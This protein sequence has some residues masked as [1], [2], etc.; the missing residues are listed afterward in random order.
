M[1]AI[2]VAAPTSGAGKT[3]IAVGL[4][5]ALARRGLRVQGFKVGPDY[6]DPTYHAIATGRPSRNLDGWLLDADAL[7]ESFHR[8]MVGADVAVIEGVMGLFDGRTGEGERASTAEVAKRLGAPVVLVL[9]AGKAA[10]SLA[11]I[12]FGC[13][14]FDPALPFAGVVLNRIASDAHLAA[15]RGPIEQEA[16]LTLLG[17]LR[18]DPDLALPERYLG[19][20]PLPENPALGAV[21]ERAADA[22]S[23]PTAA[24]GG[25][26]LDRLLALAECDPPRPTWLMDNCRSAEEPGRPIG[27][28]DLAQPDRSA[29]AGSDG[30]GPGWVVA[31][32]SAYPDSPQ[33]RRA[34]IALARDAAF[35]FYYQDNLDLLAAWGAELV[36]FSPL[37]DA[38]LPPGT[39]GIYLGGG[40][41][42]LHAAT[43]A[44]NDGLRRAIL[45]ADARGVPIWAECGGLMYL[46][47]GLTDAEGR[48]HRM[49]GLLPGWTRFDRRRLTLGYRTV[50]ARQATPFTRPGDRLRGHEFHWSTLEG[51]PES[52]PEIAPW[53]IVGPGARPD[54]PEGVRPEG[55]GAPNRLASYV[56]LHLAGHPA[57][58][59][60]FVDACAYAAGSEAAR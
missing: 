36:P 7:L 20:V 10:R 16:G 38:D 33:P 9:D 25:I 47:Q 21:V 29:P 11:A 13:R 24:G 53:E 31:A 44:A 8:A 55:Y 60:R 22:V 17:H 2:V 35:H 32:R 3:T 51:Y 19:L 18:R 5:R 42:E 23:G 14:H 46:L 12:A 43:L 45:A 50:R 26:D 39:S 57:L 27:R 54:A 40:F 6:I 41:P 34:R 1:K 49:V 30:R 48:H 56:H 58:A 37:T 59:P 28:D 52:S 4:M 15:V